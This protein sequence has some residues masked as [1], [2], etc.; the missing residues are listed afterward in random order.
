VIG[1]KEIG[2]MNIKILG[3]GCANCKK[4]EQN[5]RT[6]VKELALD[7]E[8]EKV[9]DI[10]KIVEHGV[11]STPALVVDGKVKSVGKVL[12]VEQVKKLLSE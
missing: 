12:S 8:V 4:L 1:K 7:A 6:A 9:E 11:M 2:Q 3:S 5:A 10:E